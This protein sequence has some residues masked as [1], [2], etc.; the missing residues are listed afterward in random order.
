[1][2]GIVSM[3]MA[4]VS[5]VWMIALFIGSG[6]AQGKAGI[7]Y[8]YLGIVN[9]LFSAIGFVFS[10]RCYKMEEIYTTTPNIGSFVNGGIIIVYLVLYFAGALY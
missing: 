3:L 5:F 10:L 2:L 8:G 7:G 6:M 1:M 9:L 4:M